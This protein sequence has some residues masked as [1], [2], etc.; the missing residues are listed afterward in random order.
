M[1]RIK[2]FD[3]VTE[4]HRS[5]EIDYFP[6]VDR[7]S[8][9]DKLLGIFRQQS[10]IVT[11]IQWLSF[12]ELEVEDPKSLPYGM[13]TY[14]KKRPTPYL[15]FPAIRITRDT[16]N[17]NHDLMWEDLLQLPRAASESTLYELLLKYLA[18]GELE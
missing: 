6:G 5:I 15:K 9:L 13:K 4:T 1:I 8:F 14:L 16:Q 7:L 10:D 2:H 11:T 3:G 17:P 18:E 12:L